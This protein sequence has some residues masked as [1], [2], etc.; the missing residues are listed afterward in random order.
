MAFSW[1]PVRPAKEGNAILDGLLG[2]DV[3]IEKAG[4]G[5]D[6][7]FKPVSS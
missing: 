3:S 2:F 4:L 6:H 7:F 5:N 1:L